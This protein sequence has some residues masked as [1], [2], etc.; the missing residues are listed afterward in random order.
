MKTRH[1][2]LPRGSV[3]RRGITLIE[4]LIIVT[5]VGAVLGLCAVLIQL[6]GRLNSDAR[7]RATALTSLERLARQLREDAHASATAELQEKAAAQP[8]GLR[9]LPAPRRSIAYLAQPA[10]VVR[11][12]SDGGNIVRRE[13]YRLPDD[14]NARF[15]LRTDGPCRLIVLVLRRMS[16]GGTLDPPRPLEIVALLGKDR[17]EAPERKGDPPR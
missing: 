12:E 4:T 9:L 16:E 8:A 2:P 15:M 6:L 5:M 10:E 1:P 3:S 13:A 11:T 17:A 7:A 14:G